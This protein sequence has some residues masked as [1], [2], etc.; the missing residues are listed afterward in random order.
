MII[1]TLNCGSSSIKFKLYKDDQAISEGMAE[2]I[3]L[4]D[5]TLKYFWQGQQYIEAKPSMDHEEALGLI[6]LSP[7]FESLG[8]IDAVGHRV[9]HGGDAFHSSALI[10]AETEAKIAEFIPL[11]PLHNPA[12]LAGIRAAERFLKDAVHVAVFDTAFHYTI[13]EY[14]YRYAVPSEWYDTY[15][16]RKYG[17]HGT[18]HLYVSKRAAAMLGKKAADTNLITLHIG[19]GVSCTAVKNGL[20][21]DTS[22][23]MTPLDGAI[24]G[25]RTGEIDPA[26]SFYMESVSATGANEVYAQMNRDSGLLGIT[27]RFS[28]RRDILE[29]AQKGDELCKLAIEMETYRLRQYIGRYMAVLGRTDAL[30]FTAGVGENSPLIR[31]LTLAGLEDMGIILDKQKNNMAF[32]S[33][34]ETDVSAP[35]SKIKILVIPT[36]EELVLLE[37]VKGVLDGTYADHMHYKYSFL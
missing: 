4:E 35:D 6:M 16:V 9:V 12:N 31:E 2:R 33:Q 20:S 14:A 30:V 25:T 24:M 17:F 11:S 7:P 29:H 15:K 21:V 13:P 3:G 27:G 10:T 5:S 36:N 19:N 34:G 22:M 23:G 26:I 28:D 37:D 32:S 8:K 1:L 18:S